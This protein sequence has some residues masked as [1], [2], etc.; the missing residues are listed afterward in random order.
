MSQKQVKRARKAARIAGQT[1]P[2]KRKG[3]YAYFNPDF[4][5]T[6][7]KR[8]QKFEKVGIQKVVKS[9]WVEPDIEEKLAAKRPDP[10]RAT[11]VKGR[12]AEMRRNARQRQERERH[13]KE[14]AN[15]ETM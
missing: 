14:V 12:K 7:P 4:T 9:D 2:P 1:V 15:K 6:R 11:T 13:K 8:L 5:L 3:I 10:I